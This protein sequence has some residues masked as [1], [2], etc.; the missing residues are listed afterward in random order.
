MSIPLLLLGIVALFISAI[1][2]IV[3][4]I[5]KKPKKKIFLACIASFILLIIGSTLTSKAEKEVD[6]NL[7][8]DQQIEKIITN[9]MGKEVDGKKT[10]DS[11]KVDSGIA[12][13]KINTNANAGSERELLKHAAKLI[14]PVS[15]LKGV[16]VV[17]LTFLVPMS[18]QYGKTS[19]ERGMFIN[20]NQ[21]TLKKIQW[22][23][24]DFENIPNV[25]NLYDWRDDTTKNN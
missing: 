4:V 10:I 25:A 20:M 6:K 9:E 24:F 16:K 15:K 23:N 18:D 12:Y 7:P 19:F 1:M 22:E 2:L 17:Q 8:I 13:M 21:E 5:K 11:I 14:E 3:S